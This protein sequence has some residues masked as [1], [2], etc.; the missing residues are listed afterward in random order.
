MGVQF[1]ERTIPASVRAV[2]GQRAGSVTRLVMRTGL[3]KSAKGAQ[4][5]MLIIAL[6]AIA[7][8]LYVF[9]HSGAPAPVI[10]PQEEADMLAELKRGHR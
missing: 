4:T 6:L 3:A 8:A 2:Q 7:G 5:A 10:D 9:T 1:D